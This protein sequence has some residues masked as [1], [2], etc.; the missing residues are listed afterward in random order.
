[1]IFHSMLIQ[2]HII[3]SMAME[4]H[5]GAN[6]MNSRIQD[7]HMINSNKIHSQFEAF[8]NQI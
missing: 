4:S 7:Q 2:L 6:T 8:P 1:M 5:S 3:Q